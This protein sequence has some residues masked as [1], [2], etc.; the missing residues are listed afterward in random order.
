MLDVDDQERLIRIEKKHDDL[1]KKVVH[2][3]ENLFK[4]FQALVFESFTP[5]KEQM[6]RIEQKLNTLVEGQAQIEEREGKVMVT[7]DDILAKAEALG[8]ADD[9]LEALVKGVQQQLA[10]AAGDPVKKQAIFDSLEA[11]L[12]KVNASLAANVPP[13]TVV[14]APPV[15]VIIAAADPA[16]TPASVAAA[17]TDAGVTDPAVAAAAADPAATPVS[18][19]SAVA[20]VTP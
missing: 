9:S 5:F 19:A 16:A 6:D 13:A 14:T 11:N 12:A 2:L 17:A 1:T 15:A 18:V 8:T 10:D 7:L 3:M 4:P 20:A